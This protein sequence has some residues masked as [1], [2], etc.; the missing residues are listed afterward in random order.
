[1]QIRL[2]IGPFYATQDVAVSVAFL[3]TEIVEFAMLCGADLVSVVLDGDGPGSA[4]PLDRGRR[5]GRA[6]R[7]RRAFAE[8]FD[9][10]VT[11]LARQLRSELDRDPD[12][13]PLFASWSA[14]VEEEAGGL[15][16]TVR[17]S[18]RFRASR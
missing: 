2:D 9:R 7:L 10:I 15:V 1:M 13:R 5:P 3:I 6:D 14:I 16:F 12:A 18:R 8:R 4:R 17:P 11:G